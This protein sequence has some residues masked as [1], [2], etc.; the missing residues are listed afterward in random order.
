[1]AYLLTSRVILLILPVNRGFRADADTLGV[2]ERVVVGA[3]P[4]T[5]ENCARQASL[6]LTPFGE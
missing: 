1:M 6:S 2:V 5:C 4:M 3:M